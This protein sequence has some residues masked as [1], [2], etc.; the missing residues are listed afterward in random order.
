MLTEHKKLDILQGVTEIGRMER[1]KM[2]FE[3]AKWIW[4]EKEETENQYGEF[5]E[6]F[7]WEKGAVQVLISVF[8]DYTLYVNGAYVA[9]NQSGDYP[10][11]KIYDAVDITPFLRKGDNALC[12]LAWYFGKS[13]QRH[14]TPHPGLIF[15]V[16]DEKGVLCASGKETPARLSHAYTSGAIRKITEQL[17]Y[18]FCYDA[19]AEDGWLK[20]EQEGFTSSREVAGSSHLSPRQTEKLMLKEIR[21]GSITQ[22][23]NRYLIDLGEE[24]VGLC[25][26]SFFTEVPQEITISYGELLENGSVKRFIDYRDFSVTYRA[27]KG[28]N[29]YTNYMLRFA[30][31]YLEVQCEAPLEN[32][33]FGIIPQVYPVAEKPVFMEDTEQKKIYD[34]CLN[35]LKLCMMEHYVDCP[36]REQC[37]YTFDSR[38]QML[39]G[40]SA[41]EGGN[42]T[43]ARENLFLMSKDSRRDGILSI[44][45]PSGEDFTIP[46]FSLYYI[47]AVAEYMQYTGDD[48][49][50]KAV[51]SKME[52]ILTAYQNNMENGLV[53]IFSGENHWNFYDWSEYA[54][55]N[56]R[57]D[58]GKVPDFLIN[59]ITVLALSAFSDICKRLQKEN[60]YAQM[61]K[62]I[63]KQAREAYYDTEKGTYFIRTPEE[64]ATELANSLAVL[65]GIADGKIAEEIAEKL[66]AGVLSPCS[67]SL[68]CMKYDALLKVDESYKTVILEEIR[69]T[70]LPMLEHG[71]T[72]WETALGAKDFD[73]AGSLCHGWSA[74]PIHYYKRFGCV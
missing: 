10:Q 14:H 35:T 5:C 53:C 11:Y 16:R 22:M 47:I 15:E 42:Q 19:Q 29:R 57:V 38:N 31:R 48:T 37:M 74:I 51:F 43:Y 66:A 30:C 65:S 18:S 58:G 70:Y 32:A 33:Y 69:T 23:G 49:L 64:N 41:F 72:V 73:N 8:G 40:Y 27:K 54:V 7:S 55:G 28:E 12:I 9:S 3:Q 36:W 63:T 44:C 46:S 60:R 2:A 21:K 17:G 6:T 59:A 52:E 26:F 45:F 4:I 50:G 61:Q 1:E 34:A 13:S 62:E 25:S 20:G 71:N 39:A 67:L 24:V 68:K 56:F